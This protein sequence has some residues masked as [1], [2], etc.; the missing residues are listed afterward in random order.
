MRGER[1][2]TSP[3]WFYEEF[4]NIRRSNYSYAAL[5]GGKGKTA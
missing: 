1:D 5:D 3:T 4:Q 2:V